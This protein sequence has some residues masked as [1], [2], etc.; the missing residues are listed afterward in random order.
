[1]KN[2][3]WA[4]CIAAAVALW[5]GRGAVRAETGWTPSLG[6]QA[7]NSK[8]APALNWKCGPNARIEGNLLIV[9]V[10]VGEENAGGLATADLDLSAWD[11]RPVGATVVA[12]GDGTAKSAFLRVKVK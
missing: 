6:Q 5:G 3:P 11:G 7:E 4:I 10:P 8:G 2:R 12:S 1:M 9:D